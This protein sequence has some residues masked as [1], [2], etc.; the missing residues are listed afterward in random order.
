MDERELSYVIW[1]KGILNEELMVWYDYLRC[2]KGQGKVSGFMLLMIMGYIG[3]GI[4]GCGR[5][6]L[7]VLWYMVVYGLCCLIGSEGDGGRIGGLVQ[8]QVS[9]IVWLC[10]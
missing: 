8:D 9:K 2:V 7:I 4:F 3:G 5:G 10:I 6:W 1:N